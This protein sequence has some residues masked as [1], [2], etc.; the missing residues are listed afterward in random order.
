MKS[1]RDQ[2]KK[3]VIYG[4]YLFSNHDT[5]N[6]PN[7]SHSTVISSLAS[8]T[9]CDNMFSDPDLDHIFS[10]FYRVR[11]WFIFCFFLYM[12]VIHLLRRG[13]GVGIYCPL[14]TN[15]IKSTQAQILFPH[16]M[17]KGDTEPNSKYCLKYYFNRS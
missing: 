10:H 15:L 13:Q 11:T 12:I 5:S 14:I 2:W 7:L 1:D 4:F 9:K 17:Q 3:N 6:I 16:Q 8:Q